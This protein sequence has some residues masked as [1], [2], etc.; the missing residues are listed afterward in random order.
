MAR[1]QDAN[2][3]SVS[4]KTHAVIVN[5][6]GALILLAA[7]VKTQQI[8]RVENLLGEEALCR[9]ASLGR[10]FMGKTQ[11]AVEFIMPM[12]GFWDTGPN[13]KTVE[14]VHTLKK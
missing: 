12:P 9:V 2:N 13:S 10:T 11:V 1:F 3:H 5:D 8:I 7:A 14:S 4:E 6:H